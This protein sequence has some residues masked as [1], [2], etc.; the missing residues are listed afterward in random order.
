[1]ILISK[2]P[3]TD[4]IR[5]L[6]Y[7]ELTPERYPDFHL[8][9]PC[10][11]SISDNLINQIVT[12]GWRAAQDSASVDLSPATDDRPFVAQ[13]GLWRNL[14]PDKL[15][16]VSRYAEFRG[17]PLTKI[18]IAVILA[19][20]LILIIPLN[21]L[22][23]FTRG[24]HLRFGPWLY[25]FTIGLAFIS[26]EII[27]IQKYTLFIGASVYSTA[28][29]LLT[30]LV[31]SGIGSRFA[32][33]VGNQTAF[34]GIVIWLVLDVFVLRHLTNG[35]SFLGVFPRVLVSAMLIFPVGFFMG[36][37][38]PKGALRVRE[39]VDWGF[40]VNGAASVLG[41]TVIVL[42]A[43]TYGFTVALL[44]A[45]ALYLVANLLLSLKALW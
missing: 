6:A 8:L 3:L 12:N 11:D 39:L 33:R 40:A 24:E 42:I 41:A 2:R 4:E 27:L 1:M 38:F 26:V 45:A 31:A 10:P 5:N 15:E 28:A 21:L 13:M 17:F 19:V 25:F 23:Y 32:R 43:F 44:L 29:V 34:W 20:I 36:M 14:K 18:M 30:L 9:Y 16:N 22:P 37:P 7:R 35:L